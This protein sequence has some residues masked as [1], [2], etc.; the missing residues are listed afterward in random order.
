MTYVEHTQGVGEAVVA[1]SEGTFDLVP[2]E[3][4]LDERAVALLDQEAVRLSERPTMVGV[5]TSRNTSKASTYS[6]TRERGV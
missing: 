6:T 4:S 3:V 2:L 1:P 5:S